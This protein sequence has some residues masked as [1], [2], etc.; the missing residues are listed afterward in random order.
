M[1]YAQYVVFILL[2]SF[3]SCKKE[4]SASVDSDSTYAISICSFNIQF[5][6]NST[7]R[8]NAALISVLQDFD[9][10]VIQE[11]VSPPYPGTFPD[12]TPYKP[13][14]ESAAFFDLML[15]AGFSFY[16]SEEDTGTGDNIHRN[17]SSTEWWVAFYKPEVLTIDTNLPHGFL[18]DDRSNNPLYERVPY[19]FGFKTCD[20]KLD[21]SLISVHLQ[22]GDGSANQ[23]RRE[24][25]FKTIFS[26]IADRDSIE[27]DFL[28]LGDMN[29]KNC[30]EIEQ[31]STLNYKSLNNECRATN[32]NI[33]GLKPYDNVFYNPLYTSELDSLFDMQILDLIELM[34]PKW[35]AVN[36]LYPG[37]PYNH[38]TFRQHYSDHN[39]ISF[40]LWV[41]RDDD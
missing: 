5:L 2:F 30:A 19:A 21:F 31:T 35:D 29:F 17:G 22:P 7:K 34:E 27:K 16:L 6:G 13:D 38:N 40:R 11:L 24:V 9:V 18:A 32:T 39:P 41:T 36:G 12:G 4:S 33:N 23:A 26:W 1:K 10:V 3:C 28:V 25:E 8:D 15:A 37:R 14:P 20:S